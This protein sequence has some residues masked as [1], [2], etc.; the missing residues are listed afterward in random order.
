[1]KQLGSQIVLFDCRDDLLQGDTCLCQLFPQR[2]R[3]VQSF[4][5][6]GAAGY[7]FALVGHTVLPVVQ[8]QQIVVNDWCS[9]AIPP[10]TFF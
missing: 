5:A 7:G 10:V 6:N 9:R 1:M 3:D 8:R 2:I 4:T